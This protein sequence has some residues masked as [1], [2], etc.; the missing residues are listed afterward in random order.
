VFMISFRAP[1]NRQC[2]IEPPNG[3]HEWRVGVDK[4]RKWERPK[5][6]ELPDCPKGMRTPCHSL[7]WL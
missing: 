6:R 4:V 1:S 7:T 5:A 3:L 2:C